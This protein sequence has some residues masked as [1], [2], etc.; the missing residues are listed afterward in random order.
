MNLRSLISRSLAYY[1]QTGIVVVFGLGVATAVITGSLLIGDSVRGSLRDTALA[2]LGRIDYAMTAPR[3]LRRQFADDIRA[4]PAAASIRNLSAL[5]TSNGAAR[6]PATEATVPDVSV[7]G[8]EDSFWSFYD[9][10]QTPE[11]SGR[12]CA[13]NAAL[14]RDLS[15][16]EGD[17]L[18]LT[19]H[20]R[21][22][23][24]T[25]T[26]FARRDKQHVAPM[27]R[28]QVEY[29]LPAGGAGDFR[30]DAQSAA[31]RNVFIGRQW[32]ADRLGKQ[33]S[34]NVLVASVAP[35]AQPEAARDL[36]DAVVGGRT[37]ADLGLKL[38]PDARHNCISLVGD[39]ILLSEGQVESA[40]RAAAGCDAR[41]T[42]ASVYLATAITRADGVGGRESAYAMIAGLKPLQPFTLRAGSGKR[43]QPGGIWL[44]TWA[45]EDLQAAVGD[46]LR[47]TYM[48]PTEDGT[49]PTAHTELTVTGIVEMAGPA[50]DPTLVPDFEGITDAAR[51]G[52]WDPPFPVD[53]SRI[54]DRDEEYWDRYRATPRGF[55]SPDTA[56]AMWQSGP[57][58]SEADWVT[59]I[60]MVPPPDTTLG[61][62]GK[63]FTKM[64]MKR[65]PPP[66]E[67]LVFRPVRKLA[68]RAAQGTSDFG[69]LLLGLS[70]F[71][72]LSGAGL[73]GMLLRLSI[74]RRASQVGIMLAT[75]VPPALVKRAIFAEGAILTVLGMAAGVPAGLLYAAGIIHALTSWWSGALGAA[76]SLWLHVTAGSI[77]TGAVSG[78]VIGLLTTFWSARHL[79]RLEVLE[80]L[81]GWRGMAVSVV[82]PSS[83]RVVFL[84]ILT[85]TA[86]PALGLLAVVG[87]LAPQVAFFGIGFALLLAALAASALLLSRT[88]RLR[89]ATRS[90][91]AFS[92]RNAAA[93]ASRSL[94]VIGLLAAAT[95]VIVAV[96]ANSR[97]F[98]RMDPTDRSSGTGGFELQAT[99]SVPLSFDLGT[100]AGRSNLGFSA[101]DEAAFADVKVVSFLASQGEDISCLNIA[102]PSHPRILGVPHTMIQRGGFSPGT[103][104][105]SF[106]D[107]PWSLLEQ[108]AADDT[109]PAFGD[110]ASVQWTLHSG[111]GKTYQI[112]TDTLRPVSLRFVGVLPGSIFQ[113]EVL[114]SE[115]SF[116]TLFPSVSAPSYFLLDVPPGREDNI[117]AILRTNLGDMGVRVRTTREVLNEF[118]GVQNTYLSMFLALGG[119]GLLLGTAGLVTV[120]LRSALE[121]RSELALMLAVGFHRPKVVRVLLLENGGLLVAGLLLGTGMALLAVAPHLASAQAHVNWHVLS[122]VLLG[123][124]LFGL[125]SCAIAVHSAVRGNLV[126]AL[127]QE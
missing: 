100:P 119:L 86:A 5:L 18:L 57:Q 35:E 54:T 75:G 3:Y 87:V 98:S 103:V 38:V 59:S 51:I 90:L 73:G 55:V 50:A 2:R 118:I 12:A 39:G 94:L 102:R 96:A 120:L 108:P 77:V 82:R 40:I 14:A 114:V 43:P 116:H 33:D 62:F 76:P 64:L 104:S 61:K 4:Q 67:G 56:R 47:L 19:V 16:R 127:R 81:G 13:V 31:P 101:D 106:A 78:L 107:Q 7:W 48:V 69:Q 123:I 21:S 53:F 88:L 42:P 105:D 70:M 28:V 52:E 17:Y 121:R 83:R 8:V 45:A 89:G 15:L 93:S 71:L 1:W 27:M 111:L 58:G 41:S 110:A 68:L 9:L 60:R 85:L 112:P 74:D 79:G 23:I 37:L 99:S 124:L 122:G 10:P 32:L 44:N 65:T 80:L 113:R 63:L 30:L 92:A 6:N 20:K 91:P 34:M 115:D 49:Y 25:E 24:S 36:I 11:L 72:V 97:D 22:A 117:A 29:I 46:R 66:A 26:L 109:I 125:V 95:F 84:L 126:A